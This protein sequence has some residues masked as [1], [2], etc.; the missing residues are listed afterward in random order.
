MDET[1]I[2]PAQLASELGQTTRWVAEKMRSGE[3]PSVKLGASR[4]FTP[5]C[6]AELVRRQVEAS[7]PKPGDGWGRVTRKRRRSA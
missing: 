6:R 5:E 1:W 4:Y 2:T 3:I 7:T